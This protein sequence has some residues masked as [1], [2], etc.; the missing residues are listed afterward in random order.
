M[1]IKKVGVV[2]AGL[3]G[4]GIAQVSAVAGY[5]TVISEVSQEFLDKGLSKIEGFLSKAVDKSKM[6]SDEKETALKNLAGTT[7]MADLYGC[8]LII[9]AVTE[10]IKLKKEL[11]SG[12]HK[13]CP[14][15]TIFASNTSS[16]TVT[17][18]AAAT[19]RPDRFVGLHFFNPVP[20]MKLVEVVRTIQTSQDTFD[21]AFRFAKSLGNTTKPLARIVEP[22]RRRPL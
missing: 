10:D 3:M 21:A 2:G 20:I 12:L 15:T 22:A 5:E 6:S 7:D 13:N 19:D 8:D 14:E 18:M 11:F 1:P 4:S 16:L 17:E 9:E